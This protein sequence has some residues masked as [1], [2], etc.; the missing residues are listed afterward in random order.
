[1]SHALVWTE[2]SSSDYTTESI[3]EI[4]Y[5]DLG[6]NV[7][8][9]WNKKVYKLKWINTS[10]SDV[11]IWLDNEHADIYTTSAFPVIKSTDNLKILTD[12]GFQFRFT[13]LDTFTINKLPNANAATVLNL[14]SDTLS[15]V[16]KR[17]APQY[18]DGVKI[19][20]GSLVLVKS[21]STASEN[22][23]YKIIAQYSGS[24]STGIIFYN[25]DDLIVAGK[26]VSVG[27]S[28]Y[29][30]YSPYLSPFQSAALGST[31]VI[32][33]DRTT[34]YRL[35]NV[36]CSTGGSNL[37]HNID[38]SLTLSSTVLDGYSVSL[39][40]RILVK[41]QTTKNQNGIYYVSG[42]Y[43]SNANSIIDPRSSTS[44]LD[45][46][47]GTISNSILINKPVNVTALNGS[48]NAGKY[49]RYFSG[50][51]QTG[52]IASTSVLAWTNATHFYT[53]YTAD[54]YYEISSTSGLGFSFDNVGNAGTLTST[55][56]SIN[57]YNNSPVS[58]S[59]N[60]KILVKHYNN[61]YSGVYNVTRV[62]G[63]TSGVWTR[64]TNFDSAAEIVP[65]LIQTTN[66][67][68]TY[69]GN[70]F[71]FNKSTTYKSNFILNSDSVNISQTY[72]P[73][74]YEPVT[75]VISSELTNFTTVSANK[76]SNAGIALSQRVLVAGQATT[77][78]Q[79]GIYH[80]V[81]SSGSTNS[82]VFDTN[83][84]I[85]RGAIAT[86]SGTGAS[87]FL[88]APGTS[89]GAG[90]TQ[91]KWV[92]ISSAPLIKVS[93]V[94]SVDK[95]TAGSYITPD[96]FSVSVSTGSTILV[97]TT[98]NLVN[99]IYNATLGSATKIKTNY[100]TGLINWMVDIYKNVLTPNIAGL[101]TVSPNLRSQIK[102][103]YQGTS[104]GST[105]YG[106]LFV[107]EISFPSYD[108]YSNY[109]GSEG[110]GSA[111][112]QELN[113]DWYKQDFQKYIVKAVYH[114]SSLSGFPISSGTAISSL[115]VTGLGNT[116]IV[117]GDDVLVYIGSGNTS[118][119]TYNGIWRAKSTGA[120]K[121]IYFVKH[122]DFNFTSRYYSGTN[123]KYVASPYERPTL[124]ISN[125]Y[126]NAGTA[127]TFDK[128]Y[129]QGVLS[130]NLRTSLLGS[131]SY[132]AND[133]NQLNAGSETFILD[134]EVRLS[135]NYGN[136]QNF[137]KLAP[138]QHILNGDVNSST[139]N[140]NG[141]I[142]IVQ[143]GTRL[144]SNISNSTTNYYYDLGDRVYFQQANED[145]WY[146][147]TQKYISG[148]YQIVNINTT[149]WT[150]YL[151]KV[152][153][154]STYGHLDY[155][156]R[157]KIHA[158][159]SITDS[160]FS[161]AKFEGTGSTY[162]WS[163]SNYP[164]NLLDVFVLENG[165]KRTYTHAIDFDIE[166]T[167]GYISRLNSFGTAGELY[168][169]LYSSTEVPSYDSSP[170]Q[171]FNRYYNVDQV[172]VN[173]ADITS[174]TA[175]TDNSYTI[176]KSFFQ[177]VNQIGTATTTDIKYNR[178]RKI[179]FNSYSA[180]NNYSDNI[181][182][183]VGSA[184]T[185][186]YFYT[187]R[188]SKDGYYTKSGLANTS[189]FYDSG[190]TDPGTGKSIGLFAGSLYLEKTT[191]SGSASTN[192][193]SSLS[194][195]TNQNV[196]V[197]NNTTTDGFDKTL[198]ESLQSS[199]IND[200]NIEVVHK[201]SGKRDQK[202][203]SFVES[204]YKTVDLSYSS[205]FGTTL[206]AIRAT[207]NNAAGVGTFCLYFD[208]D[209]TS[210]ATSE[211]S[212]INEDGR[213]QYSYDVVSSANITDFDNVGMATTDVVEPMSLFRSMTAIPGQFAT[214]DLVLLKDQTDTTKNGIYVIT[215]NNFYS[216][217]RASDFSTNSD[218]KALGRVSFNNK[219]YELI[220]PDD[221]SYTMGTTPLFWNQ[222]KTSTDVNITVVSSAN[223]SGV[224]LTSTI[225]DAID[226]YTLSN[227]DKVLLLGQTSKAERYIGRFS[228]NSS[229]TLTRVTL[230]GIA[231]SSYFSITNCY[232]TDTN[233]NLDYEL[234]FDPSLTSLGTD[235]IQWFQRN[236]ISS[237]ANCAFGSTT[238]YNI[239]STSGIGISLGARILLKSQSD[240]KENGIYILD[241][242][243]SYFLGRHE[244][245]DTSSELNVNKRVQVLGGNTAS[246]I[247]GLVFDESVT[248]TIDSSNIYWAKVTDNNILQ[249]CK[250]A[251]VANIN[252]TS[253]PSSIDDI[254]LE[255]GDRILLKDQSTASQNG[256][257]IVS[258][259]VNKSWVRA[260]DLDTS[261]KLV[262]QLTTKIT[263]GSV[264]AENTYRI[265]LGT[266]L[267]ITNTQL[268]EYIIGTSSINWV[269]VD[270]NGLI[271]QSPETWTPILAGADNYIN[272]GNAKMGTD[273]IA[274][275]KRFAIAVK[276]PSAT[277][278]STNGITENGKVRNIK[279][280]IEYK[281]IE[282]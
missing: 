54:F 6:T 37:T 132:T 11:K 59:L 174:S 125:S 47:W 163:E 178:D 188:L 204:T 223:Y 199:Y 207:Y 219:T 32:W 83:Y 236:Y 241:T 217:S 282:D 194:L 150:Y 211:R 109:F 70:Y 180:A 259:A 177:V 42:L 141:D 158:N 124:V 212:W 165:I 108:G 76:F 110:K 104:V 97:N 189:T 151:R 176:E 168:V 114:S 234:Y 17:V 86:S 31:S 232:V 210:R 49:Y 203:F 213:K 119:S 48:L 185:N 200:K 67:R 43:A 225:P 4:P 179:I 64:A 16:P 1:M 227:N 24:G 68:N 60:N 117:D 79:N 107:P 58:L 191:S 94:T 102:G 23:L 136:L 242:Q 233:K 134:S 214:G 93:A 144:F 26:I 175:K 187:S 55:P 263:S 22:G 262:P 230:G 9:T 3:K 239:N 92:N 69:G 91:V 80:V 61:A 253:L 85:V 172:L 270:S 138:I 264:N 197:Y 260:E 229:P 98:N 202:I 65:T 152:K 50:T 14:T 44:S 46:Y 111:L 261:E 140:I 143:R 254:V 126:F 206:S 15:G 201:Y 160:L 39:N 53:A 208:P 190:L 157:L 257:Y 153:Y 171:S 198:S 149:T 145:E 81:A 235:P 71:Y 273:G 268:T 277:S 280:K 87:Y 170:K 29:Y 21:Q 220:V 249:D 240:N 112:L 250:V 266:P 231:N 183:I 45:S 245:L 192:W 62:G 195:S 184:S 137:P 216:L 120:A 82:L 166:P 237:Y 252:L 38:D 84:S 19:G 63:G 181:N 123:T 265:K 281:T 218:I 269:S 159:N 57:D 36:A 12:L 33:N 248:N 2:L 247:Y 278:L 77:A 146:S 169:F 215:P 279:F 51:A 228:Q 101:Y 34:T 121:R 99:G 272:I 73:Y 161:L 56:T 96:D 193:F 173:K 186:Q 129:M 88:Y 196:L 105:W 78:S 258:D 72:T 142:I 274:E 164:T 103:I 226:G 155:A 5:S 35:K 133:D 154:N 7:A 10:V 122:E 115:A 130:N 162:T 127:F 90:S 244:D 13:P 27:S 156:R 243:A 271:E 209:S 275:S 28:S 205:A 41:D 8:G 221:N 251:S 135:R 75:N 113:I 74:N 267:A 224:A 52:G 100:A 148:I 118:S 255:K 89:T 20:F 25:G 30:A 95:F 167:Y 66:N 182:H 106:E 256:I 128:V 18:I 116:L 131:T 139:E 238:N 40:D 222:I 276:T 246:G 147:T